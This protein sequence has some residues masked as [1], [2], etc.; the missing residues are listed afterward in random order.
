MKRTIQFTLACLCLLAIGGPAF[1]EPSMP[2][3]GHFTKADLERARLESLVAPAESP[4]EWE[5]QLMMRRDAELFGE[6]GGD[7]VNDDNDTAHY[8]RGST[9]IIHVFINHTGGTWDAAERSAAGAKAHVAKDHYLS[10]APGAANISFDNQGSDAYIYYETTLG[11]NIPYSGVDDAVI[12]D[13]LAA[14]GFADGDGD[15]TRRDDITLYLQG[16]NGGY[17]NVI[18]S[19][20]TAGTGRAWASYGNATI[21]LYQDS[22]AN[23]W[24]HE[25]GHSYGACDE[26]VEN[27]LCNGGINCG[28]CQSWYLD[29][30]V[31]NGNCQLAACAPHESCIMINNTFA[32]ICPFTLNHWGWVDED[33]NGQL[34]NLKRRISGNSFANIYQLYHNGWFNWNNVDHGMVAHQ[35]W[36]SWS[37]IGLRSPPTGD[38]DIKLFTENNHNTQV[39]SSSYGGQTIDFVVGDYNHNRLG[40]EHVR[41]DL[42]TGSGNY[43]IGWESG[44][45]VLDPD[46]IVRAG[47]W[48]DYNVVRTWDVP[49]FGGETVSFY[50]DVQTAGMDLGMALYKSNGDV[51][52]AGRSAAV[53]SSDA[54][55]N[56][57]DEAFTYTVPSDDVYGLVVFANSEVN[58]NFSIQIGPTPLTLAEESPYLSAYDLRLFNYDP[59]ASYWSF[60][61]TR[62]ADAATGVNLELFGDE[63]YTQ[64]WDASNNYGNGAVE[65]FAV[66]YWQGPPITRDHMRVVK[67]SG[68]GNH[69]TE[70]EHDAD[71][72]Q[73]RVSE[74]WVAG[75]VG[76]VWDTYLTSGQNYFFRE[77][78]S[79]PAL[80]TGIYIFDSTG[81]GVKPRVG[82]AQAANYQPAAAGGEW[83]NYTPASTRWYGFITIVND[84]SSGLYSVWMGPDINLN[85]DA[86]DSRTDEIVFARS[87]VSANYWSIFGVRP[88]DGETASVWLYGDDAY[89]IDTL[90]GSDQS[91]AGVNFVVGDY[92]H[93]PTGVVYPRTLRT[94]G[95]GD[96]DIEWEGGSEILNYAPGGA[97]VYNMNWPVGDVVEIWDIF[98]NPG[99]QLH[100]KVEDTSGVLDLGL[101][102]FESLG[103][104][105]YGASENAAAYA[106]AN[107]QGGDESVVFTA[108]RGDWYG[109]VVFNQNERGG[110]YTITVADDALTGLADLPTA[111]RFGL[112]A[113]SENPFGGSVSLLYSLATDGMAE[114][115]IFDV[116]GRRLRSLLSE[117]RGAGSHELVWDGRTENGE[118]TPA[119]VYFA[120]LRSG[121]LQGTTKLVRV[122]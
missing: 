110:D 73:G 37:A 79:A 26:Y 116:Q 31:Q 86:M 122:R 38:Y 40:N 80:D 68:V 83:F 48:S 118:D 63:N 54:G 25:M 115:D 3:L 58:G 103:A 104:P 119:G 72:I 19:Y 44:T 32:A 78:H 56:G 120:R 114:I 94:S 12:E 45:G 87:T 34:D 5:D 39:A 97:N 101:A 20:Q 18:A 57:L 102:V 113:G 98:M 93:N 28:D 27:N 100:L 107:G 14:I 117:P 9:L 62:P 111:A 89:T 66:D 4:D 17:D 2:Q 29:A 43:D 90:A 109:I 69:R 10:Q 112:R 64:Y 51:Y 85:E 74:T 23:V 15:G 76:K 96:V 6:G 33:N 121:Q 13:A 50:L 71:I 47:T 41:I 108:T 21:V 52:F 36:T 1:A 75:H 60:I 84:E 42:W 88:S 49:L 53:A 24:A 11:Y 8:S 59:N 70:W 46:G 92:N 7:R 22:N 99:E 67:N 91:G 55:G 95:F 77:Y 35:S 65:F 106:D 82:Y 61:G 30:M 105:F 16:W 81:D